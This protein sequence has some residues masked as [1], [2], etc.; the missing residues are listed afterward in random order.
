MQKLFALKKVATTLSVA[1]LTALSILPLAKPAEAEVRGGVNGQLTN[2]RVC[3]QNNSI[4]VNMT[5]YAVS[6]SSSQ[7]IRQVDF[8]IKNGITDGAWYTS[9][10]NWRHIGTDS[11]SIN[12]HSTSY[13]W[14]GMKLTSDP[15][16]A[17]IHVKTTSG[18]VIDLGGI[19][20]LGTIPVGECK[21][22]QN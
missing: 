2:V 5:A 13:S 18:W 8:K 22:Y 17:S 3:N 20:N 19:V 21:S 9:G 14:V 12:N 6:T 10:Y 4:R 11:N 1:S 16:L 7:R 15:V